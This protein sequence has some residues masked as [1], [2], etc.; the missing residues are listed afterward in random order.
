MTCAV[1]IIFKKC[2]RLHGIAKKSP[3]EIGAEN[4]RNARRAAK[5]AWKRL[6]GIL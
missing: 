5:Y 3:S 1:R 6:I 2:H 4:H